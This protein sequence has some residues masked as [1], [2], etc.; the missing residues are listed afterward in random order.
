[1]NFLTIK[2]KSKNII[3]NKDITE[4]MSLVERSTFNTNVYIIKVF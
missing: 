3:E 2:N 4:I 1:M